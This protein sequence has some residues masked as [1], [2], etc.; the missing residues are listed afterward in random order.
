MAE[1]L[2]D[3]RQRIVEHICFSA[4]HGFVAIVTC[5]Y[6]SICINIIQI[7]PAFVKFNVK[8]QLFIDINPMQFSL[9][10]KTKAAIVAIDIGGKAF[11]LE[12]IHNGCL[13]RFLF[14]SQIFLCLYGQDAANH[15]QHTHNKF[16]QFHNVLYCVFL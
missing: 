2:Y 5:L 12:K 1:H 7:E 9:L 6:D 14:R 11:F 3:D 8:R 13:E 15:G 10:L 4:F 16:S